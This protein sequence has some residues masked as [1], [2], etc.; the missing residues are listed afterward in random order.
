MIIFGAF[1]YES[2]AIDGTI[3]HLFR[4]GLIK[5]FDNKKMKQLGLER[6]IDTTLLQLIGTHHPSEY[7]L[8]FTISLLPL[9]AK[10]IFLRMKCPT[11]TD[12]NTSC[13]AENQGMIMID[14]PL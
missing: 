9:S 8:G 7:V 5:F 1:I 2:V 4:L 11:K 3:V 6:K 10:S 12:E 14:K 13:L